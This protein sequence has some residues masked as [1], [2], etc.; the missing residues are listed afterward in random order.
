MLETHPFGVFTPKNSHYLILGSFIARR[1]QDSYDWFY[2]KKQNQFWPILEKVYGVRLKGKKAKQALF[3]R[4][5]IA[6][7]DV[8]YKCERSKNNS[9]D[10][11]LTNCVYNISAIEKILK[12]NPV[13]KIFFTSQFVEKEYKKHF[14]DLVRRYPRI[15]LITLP[16]PSPRYAAMNK[17]EKIKKYSQAF[18]KLSTNIPVE[19]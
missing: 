7:T 3:K 1:T 10:S 14:Q 15:E 13:E 2:S 19:N 16:S 4:L 5:K 6:V 12:E 17:E 8:I 9:L 18:P 11:S